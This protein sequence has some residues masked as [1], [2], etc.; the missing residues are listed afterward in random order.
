LYS[1]NS[2]YPNCCRRG[3]G[4]QKS[5]ARGPIAAASSLVLNEIYSTKK[6]S[7]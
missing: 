1:Q 6:T 7:D 4:A 5:S 2:Y 3:R